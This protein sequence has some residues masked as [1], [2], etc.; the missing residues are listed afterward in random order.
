MDAEDVKAR[1]DRFDVE[2][3]AVQKEID[4]HKDAIKGLEAVQTRVR[5]E[6]DAFVREFAP[7]DGG[8]C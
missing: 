2:L 8:G 6:K 4:G 3:H 1:C 5:S 7:K